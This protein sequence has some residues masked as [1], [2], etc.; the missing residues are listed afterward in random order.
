MSY[1]LSSL[2]TVTCQ[3][4][5]INDGTAYNSVEIIWN[6]EPRNLVYMPPYLLAFTSSTIEIRMASNGS[7]MQTIQ[8]PDL[9]LISMKVCMCILT[10]SRCACIR[11]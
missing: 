9:K 7:L 11:R 6:A 2:Y 3:L 4:V 1:S 5:T 8:T 10:N